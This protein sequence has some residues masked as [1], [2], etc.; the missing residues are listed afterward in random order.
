MFLFCVLKFWW[1]WAEES[2]LRLAVGELLSKSFIDFPIA[3]R[4][5]MHTFAIWQTIN[6]RIGSLSFY[7]YLFQKKNQILR[8]HQI[9][10]QIPI[11]ISVWSLCFF[12][13]KYFLAACESRGLVIR[14]KW[15]K[16]M[17]KN[18]KF[19]PRCESYGL[20]CAFDNVQSTFVHPWNLPPLYRVAKVLKCLLMTIY[21]IWKHS[22]LLK[23]LCWQTYIDF[24]H[25]FCRPVWDRVLALQ[26]GRAISLAGCSSLPTR[27][28]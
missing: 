9:W 14:S 3:G 16:W 23:V 25:F 27:H 28:C 6:T 19:S 17:S 22:S 8:V 5:R 11:E 18:V 24:S 7:E 15:P 1:C 4:L 2:M 13:L 26:G 20:D 10:E 12:V 21:K